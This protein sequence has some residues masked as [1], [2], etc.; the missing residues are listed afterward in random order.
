MVENALDFFWVSQ[1]CNLID[2]L[3]ISLIPALD[4]CFFGHLLHLFL[5]LLH[6]SESASEKNLKNAHLVKG[7]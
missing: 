4:E 6:G 1:I 2:N 3:G 7:T 5:D